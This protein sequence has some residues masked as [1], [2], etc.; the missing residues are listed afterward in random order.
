M[1][2]TVGVTR[3]AAFGAV[4]AGVA[5]VAGAVAPAH[6]D[7]LPV[8]RRRTI[9]L[10][11]DSTCAR[12]EVSSLRPRTGWGMAL[13]YFLAP[14]TTVIN[15]A[16]TGR[17]SKS[18]IAEGRLAWI[19]RWIRAGDLLIIQFGHNDEHGTPSL[20]TEPWTTYRSYLKRYV[21]GARA[22][23]AVPILVTPP[24]RRVFDSLGLLEL[25][26][27]E[28][29]LAMQ[30]LAVQEVVTHIDLTTTTHTTWQALGPTGSL[31]YFDHSGS[32]H[33][34]T[35]FSPLGAGAVASMVVTG[36]LANT[37]LLPTEVRNLGSV[38]PAGWYRW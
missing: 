21:S 12:P 38:P 23:G 18:Y 1:G 29:P 10:A 6:A 28:Y 34:D 4:A 36:L 2:K 7:G 35:H 8:L 9:Y 30:E 26:H 22:K 37:H 27:G 16:S 32:R 15:R 19:L 13:P 3:R 5:G 25:S 31:R 20:H 24:E 17:S 33:D 14:G 11:S